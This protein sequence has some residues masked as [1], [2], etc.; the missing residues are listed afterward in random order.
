MIE[1]ERERERIKKEQESFRVRM[2]EWEIEI[3]K[4]IMMIKIKENYI[5]INILFRY[6]GMRVFVLS[7]LF[8]NNYF[9]IIFAIELH[10]LL[11]EKKWKKI[12][13][14]LMYSTIM[15]SNK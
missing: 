5:C 13:L 6:G 7:Y 11:G 12:I 3:P 9:F 15:L 1:R 4:E 2:S 8:N 10:R 14:K